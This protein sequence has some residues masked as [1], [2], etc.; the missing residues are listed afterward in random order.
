MVWEGWYPYLQQLSLF[1][2]CSTQWLQ[3]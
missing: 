1:C 3:P 2:C